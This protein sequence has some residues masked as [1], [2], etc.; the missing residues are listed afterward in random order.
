[1][2]RLRRRPARSSTSSGSRPNDSRTWRS[3]RRRGIS[4]MFGCVSGP[5]SG[6]MGLHYVN[7]PLVLDGEIDPTRP[8]IVIYEPVGERQRAPD[9]RRLPGARRRVG[10]DALACARARWDRSSTVRGAEPVRAAA[11][12]HAARVGVEGQPDGHVRELALE[13]LVRR[14]R[15]ATSR[16]AH[17]IRVSEET[18]GSRTATADRASSRRSMTGVTLVA[19]RVVRRPDRCVSAHVGGSNRPRRAD[20]PQSERRSSHAWARAARL[21]RTTRFSRSSGPTD[22]PA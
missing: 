14:V 7:M 16:T 11:L 5:D 15:R 10:Q 20:V 17:G 13:H 9:R 8:E 2:L 1:M 12:L 6:A 21:I 4:R 22:G 19:A 18:H 3:P